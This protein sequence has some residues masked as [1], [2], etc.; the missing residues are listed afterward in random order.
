MSSREDE[1]IWERGWDGHHEE[2]LRRL[3]KLA[4]AEKLQ[5]LEEA[6]SV[7]RHLSG[8]ASD[9]VTK[10]DWSKRRG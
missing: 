8:G 6:H 4:L 1:T 3:A 9:A 5:W 10:R 7:I 2:Q